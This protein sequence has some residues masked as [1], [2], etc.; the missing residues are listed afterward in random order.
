[1]KNKIQATL[2]IKALSI[3]VAWQGRRY[4]S[5]QGKAFRD[6]CLWIMPIE[7]QITG[8]V[9]VSITI[10]LNKSFLT[11]DIDNC[12]KPLIDCIVKKGW[13]TD[14]RFILDL[15]MKKKKAKTDYIKITIESI[16]K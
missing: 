4:F 1:M 14:D 15:R 5:A 16:N 7:K 6:E 8:F 10:G 12:A 13:I 2:D 9:K 11:R 3:N